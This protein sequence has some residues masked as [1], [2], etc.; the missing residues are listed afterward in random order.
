[1]G[2][3]CYCDNCQR[4]LSDQNEELAHMLRGHELAIPYQLLHEEE[5]GDE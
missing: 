1:M 2:E 3:N 4:W 5:Q